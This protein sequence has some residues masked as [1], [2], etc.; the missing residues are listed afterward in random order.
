MSPST[1]QTNNLNCHIAV[2][3][4]GRSFA[5]VVDSNWAFIVTTSPDRP[6]TPPTYQPDNPVGRLGSATI[7]SNRHNFI[8]A[9]GDF[10]VADIEDFK[11]QRRYAHLFAYV[12]YKDALGKIVHH[13]EIGLLMKFD[14]RLAGYGVQAICPADHTYAE[15]T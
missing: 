10:Q 15:D 7:G 9:R 4:E 2:T 5:F 11:A 12:D 3:N 14:Q 8:F 6:P 13:S 1:L